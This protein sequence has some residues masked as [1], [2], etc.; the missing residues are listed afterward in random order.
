MYIKALLLFFISSIVYANNEIPNREPDVK[1]QPANLEDY[2]TYDKETGQ[3]IWKEDYNKFKQKRIAEKIEKA[4]KA[5]LRAIALKKH[6]QQEKQEKQEKCQPCPVCPAIKQGTLE[7]SPKVNEIKKPEVEKEKGILVRL[8]DKTKSVWEK[9]KEMV[10]T[11]FT[12][13]KAYFRHLFC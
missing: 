9:T 10:S 1:S 6:Q 12:K 13:I 8:W 2:Y 11:I 7:V 4:K 5:K 3:W